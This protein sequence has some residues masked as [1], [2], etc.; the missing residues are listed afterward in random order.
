[1]V[2]FSITWLSPRR[3][4]LYL[5][6]HQVIW[7]PCGMKPSD[8]SSRARRVFSLYSITLNLT[9][10][11]HGSPSARYRDSCIDHHIKLTV[12]SSIQRVRM[13]RNIE[14][15]LFWHKKIQ[16][17][18]K[19][20]YGSTLLD[21]SF[22]R[23]NS[24]REIRREVM[25]RQM[26]GKKMITRAPKKSIRWDHRASKKETWRSG[27]LSSRQ[28]E[29]HVYKR[30]PLWNQWAVSSPS[31]PR[32]STFKHNRANQ[33]GEI[34]D[35]ARQLSTMQL[36][37]KLQEIPIMCNTWSIACTGRTVILAY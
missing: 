28:P 3:E 33:L 8:L 29:M 22:L 18:R 26:R 10:T 32:I 7:Q 37:L 17:E 1:M 5:R 19:M 16:E 9:R 23:R 12:P 11:R 31:R 35:L 21:H 15:I 36:T 6:A 4:A 27:R 13:P 20:L 34:V 2:V 24:A 25:S 30:R 14:R